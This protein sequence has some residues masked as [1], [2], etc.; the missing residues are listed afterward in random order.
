MRDAPNEI[1]RRYL[2]LARRCTWQQIFHIECDI[3]AHRSRTDG[4]LC[5][6][7]IDVPHVMRINPIIERRSSN[8]QPVPFLQRSRKTTTLGAGM[9]NDIGLSKYVESLLLVRALGEGDLNYVHGIRHVDDGLIFLLWLRED[10]RNGSCPLALLAALLSLSPYARGRRILSVS[11][12]ALGVAEH[13]AGV[14]C[15]RYLEVLS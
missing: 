15:Y 3:K 10:P 4:V 9:G 6:R 5:W 1:F 7:E 14:R 11:R 13:L 12:G 2:G 8:A